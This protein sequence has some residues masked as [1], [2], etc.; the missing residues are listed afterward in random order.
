MKFK[1]DRRTKLYF[2][3]FNISIHIFCLNT[4][5]KKR[6]YTLIISDLLLKLFTFSILHY[7]ALHQCSFL[8]CKNYKNKREIRA[9]YMIC[10]GI[11]NPEFYFYCVWDGFLFFSFS[12]PLSFSFSC[13]LLVLAA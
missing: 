3:N 2:V 11:N 12:L 9:R 1:V 6:Y 5:R 13:V 8:Y 4:F 10:R 7:Y